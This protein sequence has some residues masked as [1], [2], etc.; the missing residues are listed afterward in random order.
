[1]DHNALLLGQALGDMLSDAMAHRDNQRIQQIIDDLARERDQMK[2]QRDIACRMACKAAALTGALEQA[3][4]DSDPYHPMADGM[5][6]QNEIMKIGAH[7]PAVNYASWPKEAH[8]AGIEFAKKLERNPS[9]PERPIDIG[10]SIA[11][12][13][14]NLRD[15]IEEQRQLIEA[16]SRKI[17]EQATELETVKASLRKS[18]VDHVGT[19]T[20]LLSA[21][22]S[23][24]LNDQ[25]SFTSRLFINL[26]HHRALRAVALSELAR[27]APDHPMVADVRLRE[28]V[29]KTAEM[30][31]LWAGFGR[32]I[33]GKQNGDFVSIQPK[34]MP[35]QAWDKLE[36][37]AVQT[38][39]ERSGN[40]VLRSQLRPAAAAQDV[41][42]ED[43]GDAAV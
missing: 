8:R 25:D 1:M 12:E 15:Q 35:P 24:R 41:G 14:N 23:I 2:R 37:L 42:V 19:K 28:T 17:A 33:E 40:Y 10:L 21:K 29:A 3:L 38:F 43:A 16:Q 32:V 9:S 26:V 6:A 30:N 20:A 5:N 11:K 4:V 13:R 22:Q 7:I 34:D 31:V 36:S 27:L 18:E 39:H